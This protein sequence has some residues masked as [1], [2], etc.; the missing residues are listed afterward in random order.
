MT[1][2]QTSAVRRSRAHVC[3][4]GTTQLHLRSPIVVALWS[5]IFPGTGHLLLSLYIRGFILFIWEVAVNLL[6]HLNLAIFYTF[7][8]R[9][10]LAKTVL[11][12]RWILF[13]IPVYLFSIWDSHRIAVKLNNQFILAAREDA[14]VTPF[15]LHP[16]GINY[17]DK[18]SP[19]AAVLWSMLAPG[20][21]QL[22]NHR[23]IVAFFLIGW[24]GVIIYFSR[25]LSAIHYTMLGQFAEAAA[26]VDPHWLLNIPSVYFFG[27]YDA[28]VDTVESNKLFNWEQGKFLRQQYQSASFPMPFHNKGGS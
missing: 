1:N 19:R 21:G 22:I 4:L 13:Y 20:L 17:I 2:Q 8:G 16:L 10:E 18:G 5:A 26:V 3:I 12:I 6:S 9:F 14:P 11:D 25:V 24:W 7:T 23:L 27:I 28:Y 15:I